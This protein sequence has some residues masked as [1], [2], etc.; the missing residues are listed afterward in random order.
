[1]VERAGRVVYAN[2]A[3]ARLLGFRSPAQ[4]L[5]RVVSQLPLPV[6]PVAAKSRRHS[7][8]TLGQTA[9][10]EF[11]TSRFEFRSRGKA[12]AVHVLR[13]V[14]QRKH[15]EEQ[16]RDAQR[17]ES[18]GRVV[19]GVA[20]DFNNLLTAISLYSDLLLQQLPPD[21]LPRHRAQEIRAAAQQGME[22]VQQLLAIASHRPLAPRKVSLNHVVSGMNNLLQRLLGDEVRLQTIAGEPLMPVRVDPGQIQ[23]VV[24]NLVMNGRDAINGKGHVTLQ[25]ANRKLTPASARA[26]HV[27]PGW[28]ATLSVSDTGCGM[29]RQT[30]ERIFEP[31]FTTKPGKGTG[32]GMVTVLNIVKESGGAILV[33]SAPG[34][35]TRVE[36]L[37]PCAESVRPA[38]LQPGA[39]QAAPPASATILLVEDDARERGSLAKSLLDCGYHVLQATDGAQALEIAKLR[40]APIHLLLSDLIVP[41]VCGRQLSRLLQTMHPE[42][43]PLFLSSFPEARQFLDAG[44][45]VLY[46][47]FTPES[48]SRKVRELLDS[49]VPADAGVR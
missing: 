8:P 36:V 15:L 9:P 32:L 10:P 43:R 34:R 38:V 28:Y 40:A 30:R 23:Q 39:A 35:G 11:E 27:S 16:L 22:L 29:D 44:A 33:D 46:K 24:F 6:H 18:L 42:T 49:S 48:L 13:D 47:P 45:E 1:M 14:S 5:N 19:G 3:Y 26:M 37:L 20:H 7:R 21:A 25:T 12:M 41:Q 4:V 17:L 31:F 2:P